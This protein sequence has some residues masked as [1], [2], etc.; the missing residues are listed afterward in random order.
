M[1][2]DHMTYHHV[3]SFKY[4]MDNILSYETQ[5]QNLEHDHL[6]CL[7]R[8][9][10]DSLAPLLPVRMSGLKQNKQTWYHKAT[11]PP[12]PPLPSIFSQKTNCICMLPHLRYL[13]VEIEVLVDDN[14]MAIHTSELYLRVPQKV[15]PSFIP[16]SQYETYIS[17]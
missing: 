6:C 2:L 4:C 17:V 11:P 10:N 9:I 7:L 3:V 1:I 16:V 14:C 13:K 8:C 12:P 5:L 15:V